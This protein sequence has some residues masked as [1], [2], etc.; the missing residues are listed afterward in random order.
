MN[1]KEL[2]LYQNRLSRANR[3]LSYIAE[4]IA[5]TSQESYLKIYWKEFN[6]MMQQKLKVIKNRPMVESH[7]IKLVEK[8]PLP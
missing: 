1:S 8:L 4:K 3:R 5:S 6:L 7:P 2:K